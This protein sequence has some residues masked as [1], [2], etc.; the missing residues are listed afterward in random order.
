[1]NKYL[2]IAIIIVI[3]AVAAIHGGGIFPFIDTMALI[4]VL[5]L[6]LIHI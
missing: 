6:S 3:V 5:G 4:V 1:M 2:G